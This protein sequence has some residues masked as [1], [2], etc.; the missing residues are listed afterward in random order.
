[1]NWIEIEV[2]GKVVQSLKDYIV[3][4]VG[5]SIHIN[6]DKRFQVERRNFIVDSNMSERPSE[7]RVVLECIDTTP[8]R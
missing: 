3:P 5:D 8:K 4:D 7:F 6:S 1:M 2:N